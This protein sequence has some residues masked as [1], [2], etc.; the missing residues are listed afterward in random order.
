MKVKLKDFLYD[1]KGRENFKKSIETVSMLL[2]KGGAVPAIKVRTMDVKPTKT[3]ITMEINGKFF[4]P[5]IEIDLFND[6]EYENK[7]IFFKSI[8]S[9]ITNIIIRDKLFEATLEI[10]EML[11]LDIKKSIENHDEEGLKL[12]ISS[13]EKTIK[14]KNSSNFSDGLKQVHYIKEK[15]EVLNKNMH[16][17]TYVV[18]NNRFNIK[19]KRDEFVSLKKKIGEKILIGE[20]IELSEL[21]EFL[22]IYFENTEELKTLRNRKEIYS[23]FSEFVNNDNSVKEITNLKKINNL[24]KIFESY[25]TNK[26]NEFTT[27]M[28]SKNIKLHSNEFIVERSDIKKFSNSILTNLDNHVVNECKSLF[29]KAL[30]YS[31][32]LFKAYDEV[33]R[34]K[35]GA[36]GYNCFVS[37]ID[38]L[39]NRIMIKYNKKSS[40]EIKY[41]EVRKDFLKDDL[42][43][44]FKSL[45]AKSA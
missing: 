10:I 40:M 37:Y 4:I 35:F 14:L 13:G 27:E 30:N 45:L 31:D 3:T 23:M 19:T 26:I 8:F 22:S 5:T 42:L 34:E 43:V 2:Y 15:L 7:N 21:K 17:D 16:I 44:L 1:D 12:V 33:L 28:V 41:V 20:K 25:K 9:D 11:N 39:S 38:F 24:K 29:D 36:I 6:K 18:F 32:S